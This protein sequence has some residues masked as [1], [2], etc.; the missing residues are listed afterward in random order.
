MTAISFVI[1]SL[2]EE[3]VTA[4]AI[5]ADGAGRSLYS[6]TTRRDGLGELLVSIGRVVAAR[7]DGT[8]ATGILPGT[9]PLP[10]F[11]PGIPAP[12]ELIALAKLQHDV[13]ERLAPLTEP[14]GSRTS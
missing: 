11:P 10:P 13:I 6:V 14:G 12:P 8:I 5:S 1:G 2:D 7:I 4:F 3:H 9:L